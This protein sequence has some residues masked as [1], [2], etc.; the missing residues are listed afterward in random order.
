MIKQDQFTIA[1]KALKKMHPKWML[2]IDEM[3]DMLLPFWQGT[4]LKECV[5]F[6][7]L[8]GYG[9]RQK[10]REILT[11]LIELLD[12]QNESVFLWNNWDTNS[13]SPFSQAVGLQESHHQIPKVVLT[14]FLTEFFAQAYFEEDPCDDF[15][16]VKEFIKSRTQLDF[17]QG[18]NP[19]DARGGLIISFLDSF[20]DSDFIRTRII[21]Q[22][23]LDNPI[24]YFE[25]LRRS[26]VPE[27]LKLMMQKGYVFREDLVFF[28]KDEPRHIQLAFE[29]VEIVR[30]LEEKGSEL[31]KLRVKLSFNAIDYFLAYIFY[32]KLSFSRLKQVALD[33]F[34]PV[35]WQFPRMVKNIN[36]RPSI[37][38]LEFKGGWNFQVIND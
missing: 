29:L 35:F 31:L 11:D 6:I 12:W 22:Y 8:I 34:T 7:H 38:L 26:F 24:T 23:I 3:M 37:V 21:I 18:I 32:Q 27:D 10:A 16:R 9:K 4:Q 33:F 5:H 36:P 15:L 13:P 20:G 17:Q 14:D 28:S 25:V 1:R 2:F 19:L 30:I